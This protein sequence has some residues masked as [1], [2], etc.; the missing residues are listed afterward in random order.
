MRAGN[1]VLVCDPL[2]YSWPASFVTRDEY[3][4][5]DRAKNSRNC[6]LLMDEMG[7]TAVERDFDTFK[8]LLTTS[9]HNGHVFIGAMQDYT[10][11]PLRMRKQLTQL[12]LFKCHPKEAAEWAFQFHQD[13][14]FILNTAPHLARYHMIRLRSFAP[15]EGPYT[16]AA[17]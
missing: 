2:G 15:A 11:M 8:W 9:R 10:Q 5:L 12:F 7:M 6:A 14:E 3:H 16:V 13:S 17:P 4:F 1:P